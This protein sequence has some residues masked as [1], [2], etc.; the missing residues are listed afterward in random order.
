MLFLPC[1]AGQFMTPLME[2][3]SLVI[4]LRSNTGDCNLLIAFLVEL[5][6]NV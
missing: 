2:D 1:A 3:E 6:P 5:P 4:S